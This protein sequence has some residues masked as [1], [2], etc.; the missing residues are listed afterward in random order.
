V[1]LFVLA[2]VV[3]RGCGAPEEEARRQ[4]PELPRRLRPAEVHRM[5]QRQTLPATPAVAQRPP[6]QRDPVLSALA[7][8]EAG[9]ALV[10]EANALRNSPVGQLLLDCLEA[11]GSRDGGPGPLE[12]LRALGIDPLQDVDRVAMGDEGVVVSGNFARVNW[13]QILGD[14]G[15]ATRYGSA[16]QL[17]SLPGPSDAGSGP[18]LATWGNQ[19]VII[20]PDEAAA[21]ASLDRVEGRAE[22][23]Q[24]LRDDQAYGDVYGVVG[25]GRLSGLFGG[26]ETGLGAQL[27]DTARSVELHL[28]ATRDVGLVAQV[29]GDDPSRLQDLGKALGG[30][31]VGARAQAIASGD[32]E[33]AELFDYARVVPGTENFQLEVAVPL[34]YLQAKL[35]FCGRPGKGDAGP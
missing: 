33:A 15:A 26:S 23:G 14:A 17:R 29:K 34:E 25:G 31:L 27:R 20:A 16:G 28:D 11:Q 13:D 1:V 21:R 10:F 12:E 3:A 6:R 5:E 2:A 32:A 19:M 7:A 18:V 22:P 9:T 4:P 30:A 8:P 24:V 35:A